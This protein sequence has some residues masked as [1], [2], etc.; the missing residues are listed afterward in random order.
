L[1]IGLLNV[2]CWMCPGN[3]LKLPQPIRAVLP[4]CGSTNGEGVS[5]RHVDL[6]D[7][8]PWFTGAPNR[9]KGD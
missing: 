4:R 9:R 3:N 5:Q 8:R 7:T 6:L 1:L 2:Y